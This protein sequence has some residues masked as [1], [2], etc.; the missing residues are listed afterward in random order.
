MADYTQVGTPLK[1]P[2]EAGDGYITG[3]G[4][5]QDGDTLLYTETQVRYVYDA[6]SGTWTG[7]T[8]DLDGIDGFPDIPGSF[9]GK[10]GQYFADGDLQLAKSSSGPWSQGPV[11]SSAGD[12][13]YVRWDPTTYDRAHLS[14]IEGSVSYVAF[15]TTLAQSFAAYNLLRVPTNEMSASIGNTAYNSDIKFPIELPKGYGTI[16]ETTFVYINSTDSSSVKLETST[17]GIT[18]TVGTKLIMNKGDTF[19]VTHQSSGTTSTTT[20]TNVFFTDN[21]ETTSGVPYDGGTFISETTNVSPS[22]TTPSIVT[23]VDGAVNLKPE[24]ELT[25][26]TYDPQNGAGPHASS[27]WETYEGSFPLTSTNTIT[28]V[29]T[30]SMDS[31]SNVD[32]TGTMF[33]AMEVVYGNGYY[34]VVGY[35]APGPAY[36]GTLKKSTNL[37]NWSNPGSPGLAVS[38]QPHVGFAQGTFVYATG[39]DYA[40]SQDLVNWTL[41]KLPDSGAVA[42]K[43]KYLKDAWYMVCQN[44]L[45]FSTDLTNWTPIDISGVT[46]L[47]DIEYNGSVFL[48]VGNLQTNLVSTNGVDFTPVST[49][50]TGNAAQTTLTLI[51]N[52]TYFIGSTNSRSMWKS[53]DG[54]SYQNVNAPGFGGLQNDVRCL[55]T[56]STG[57]VYVGNETQ[58]WWSDDI[59]DGTA[60]QTDIRYTFPN[61]IDPGISQN[62]T[63]AVF[64][65]YNL[66]ISS[67]A[68]TV[69]TIQKTPKDGFLIGDI[70][71][72]CSS[73]DNGLVIALNSTEMTLEGIRNGFDIGD[74][75][76]RGSGTYGLI[77]QDLN[78]AD[79]TSHVIDESK[80]KTNTGYYSRVKYRSSDPVESEWSDFSGFTTSNSFLPDF[81]DPLGGGYFAGQ[82]EDS[83]TIYNLIVAP[84]TSGGLEA[85]KRGLFYKST[86]TG[87]GST[88]YDHDLH[89]EFMTTTFADGQ[90]PLFDWCISD[91]NGPNAGTFD[92]SN[93]T[94]T[95]IGGY[96]DWYIPARWEL[97][98]IYWAL[99]PHHD[100]NN[101]SQ[102][103][104]FPEAVTPSAAQGMMTT[105]VPEQ[106]TNPLFQ[107]GGAEAFVDTSSNSTYQTSTQMSGQRRRYTRFE[108]GLSQYSSGFQA[109]GMWARAVR[110]QP[111]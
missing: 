93:A 10:D 42:T 8:G 31:F 90:H 7:A 81:G 65:S 37:L 13:I 82:Y 103:N 56:D 55:F 109:S 91:A 45:Y 1:F 12:T 18:T 34:L 38:S 71:N 39:S 72:N 28:N 104:G 85:E 44:H 17:G 24:F 19:T 4:S 80:L 107:T 110:R 69:L 43:V 95:G 84:K 48:V 111:S 75:V 66:S 64:G 59:D 88:S 47:V 63:I 108:D 33:R 30:T 52:G 50:G 6:T 101:V 32:M 53:T 62:G 11:N 102:P 74:N 14:L 78:S 41:K 54:L 77:D 20:T 3:G 25:S 87:D 23:P 5:L 51:W 79:L 100:D 15:G 9:P 22:I 26:S 49:S 40:C 83:G 2:R 99:K 97:F 29:S 61:R 106:T 86:N 73:S 57:R 58:L 98:L 105:K 46:S 96:N 68:T 27:D 67:S 76:C 92:S 21:I 16:G 94:G 89:G 60:W 70:V 36:G 35:Q